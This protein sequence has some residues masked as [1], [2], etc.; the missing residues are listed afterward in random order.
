[1]FK[2]TVY[3]T[4]IANSSSRVLVGIPIVSNTG[5]QSHR[6]QDKQVSLEVMTQRKE[7]TQFEME[8]YKNDEWLLSPDWQQLA[9]HLRMYF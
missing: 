2:T 4:E 5:Q 8:H 1:M 7:Q 9:T 6:M 3:I